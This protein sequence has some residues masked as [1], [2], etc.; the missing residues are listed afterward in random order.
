MRIVEVSHT[1][2]RCTKPITEEATA[3]VAFADMMQ[4]RSASFPPIPRFSIHP[5]RDDLA[6]SH[7][8]RHLCSATCV[9]TELNEWQAL[10]NHLTKPN[11]ISGQPESES[12]TKE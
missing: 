5:W 6:M 10:R 1:C 2:D 4:R 12:E 9:Q 11:E 3:W 8:A 7:D